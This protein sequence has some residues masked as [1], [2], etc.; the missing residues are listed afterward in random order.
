MTV[1]KDIIS[2]ST[3]VQEKI[4]YA[5]EYPAKQSA[6]SFVCDLW[7]DNVVTQSYLDLTFFWVEES[8]AD[9]KI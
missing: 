6:V 7:S 1:R 3:F 9:R 5:L 2:K 8:G 4:R